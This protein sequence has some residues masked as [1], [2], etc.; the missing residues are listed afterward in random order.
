MR[1]VVWTASRE[2]SRANANRYDLLRHLRT[3]IVEAE[4]P[5]GL[6]GIHREVADRTQE[7]DRIEVE[8]EGTLADRAVRMNEIRGELIHNLDRMS[9]DHSDFDATHF[10]HSV[11]HFL[12]E[13]DATR[14]ATEVPLERM[15]KRLQAINV[16]RQWR[17]KHEGYHSVVEVRLARII[18]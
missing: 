16:T 9:G 13:L 10:R 17:R 1:D 11:E 6:V 14:R 4:L 18:Q 5:S 12:Q 3:V 15:C 7:I 8:G 2:G